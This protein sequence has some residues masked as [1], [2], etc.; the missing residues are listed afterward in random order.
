MWRELTRRTATLALCV[1]VLVTGAS[2]ASARGLDVTPERVELTV[3]APGETRGWT[4]TATNLGTEAVSLYLVVTDVTG[5]AAEGPHPVRLS[6]QDGSGA[7]VLAE[8]A[9]PEIGSEPVLLGTV[10]PS[11]AISLHGS[12]SLPREAGN[13]YQGAGAS[14]VLNLVT[15]DAVPEA[16][17]GLAM[18]GAGMVWWLGGALLLAATGAGLKARARGARDD[19]GD[20]S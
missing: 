1:V 9:L 17:G 10:V 13:E 5:V 8:S 6:V 20:D 7:Q 2:S 11:E 18:T 15:L 3:P 19:R 14:L 12:V 4:S 16:G